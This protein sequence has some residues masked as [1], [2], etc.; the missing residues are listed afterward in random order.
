LS[1]AVHEMSAEPGPHWNLQSQLLRRGSRRP[2]ASR[3][4]GEAKAAAKTRRQEDLAT[5]F[6][7]NPQFRAVPVE[8][9]RSGAKILSA[10]FK[11][12][13]EATIPRANRRPAEK[14]EVLVQ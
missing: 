8:E 13:T 12:R 3:I 9:W 7:R 1:L 5:S 10:R 4:H 2:G 11:K 14:L 6:R